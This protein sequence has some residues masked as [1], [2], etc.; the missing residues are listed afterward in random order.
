MV[1]FLKKIC[2]CIVYKRLVWGILEDKFSIDMFGKYLK[3]VL[4]IFIFFIGLMY[5]WKIWNNIVEGYL[6]EKKVE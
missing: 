1:K 5:D 6:K 2:Y 4:G 3:L